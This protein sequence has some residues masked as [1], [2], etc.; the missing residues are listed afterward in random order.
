[1]KTPNFICLGAQKAGTTTL[2]DILRHHPQI[3]LPYFKE[4]P[5]FS[6]EEPYSKGMDWWLDFY[7][8]DYNDEHILGVMTP[9]Y[10]YYEEVPQR[11][12][13]DC[14]P[15]V[16]LIIIL[17]EPVS[18]S[19]SQYLMSVRK[20]FEPLPF[21]EAIEKED[22]RIKQ[23][24]FERNGFSYI[25]RGKYIEQ[26]KRYQDL[27]A[28]ENILFLC[29][30]TEICNKIDETIQR[31]QSF[32]GVENLD[33]DTSI[34]SNTAK[35][36]RSKYFQEISAKPNLTKKIFRALFGARF[37]RWVRFKI[38]ALN[39]KKLSDTNRLSKDEK[40]ALYQKFYKSDFEELERMTGL[41]LKHWEIK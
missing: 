39:E 31:V 13:D 15:D 22:E 34:K 40:I 8:A 16:K 3:Y 9:E 5:F 41:D 37:S 26:I 24:P 18:R 27:F 25:S 32:L 1:M 35:E 29:F 21:H 30:E 11:I 6:E 20:G 23:G 10:L 33:L 7:F 36:I 38:N 17:R 19:H 12:Y 2:H 28:A 14:G 4:A